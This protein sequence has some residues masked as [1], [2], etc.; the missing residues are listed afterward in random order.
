MSKN[1]NSLSGYPEVIN[2]K[3]VKEIES[4]CEK[5]AYSFGANPICLPFVEKRS[6]FERSVGSNTDIVE[7]EM[8][9]L[10][11][12][13]LVLRPEGTAG[14]VRAWNNNGGL[15][16]LKSQKWFYN[17]YMFRNETPQSGR[18]KQFKQ[19]GMECLGYKEGLID[20]DLLVSLNDL[21]TDLNIRE[22]VIL[23]INTIGSSEERKNYVKI[24]K[25]WLYKNKEKLDS[26]SLSRIETNTLRIFDSK[27]EN[28]Q[29][30][31]KQAPKLYDSLSKNTKLNFTNITDKLTS[32]NINFEIDYNLVRG[33]D[34][35][36]GLVF[37]FIANT[38]FFKNTIA[39]GGR[40]DNLSKIIGGDNTPAIGFAMGLERLSIIIEEK[41]SIRDGY[42]ICWLDN[43][44]DLALSIAR[45]YR[46][47]SKVEVDQ[48]NRKLN[49]QMSSADEKLFK[50]AILIGE[51]EKSNN[52]ITLKNLENGQEEK[53]II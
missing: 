53:I 36:N 27:I 48:G 44:E 21:F 29:E 43:C 52:Y 42:Y 9:L 13:D 45:K 3:K 28:T 19:F 35:Y 4:I 37:E 50:Y 20:I 1:F 31:L 6:L 47:I 46:K 30:I 34:Y 49:K 14:I 16:N 12:K 25:E 51:N 8:L 15:R 10:N 26:L 41:E 17:D 22:K 38:E 2:N 5:W 33:L 40:Y 24:F 32:L 11:D 7:K 23:K 39:A 18:F